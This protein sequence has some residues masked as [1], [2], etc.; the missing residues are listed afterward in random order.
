MQLCCWLTASEYPLAKL[1][2]RVYAAGWE[3]KGFADM[4]AQLHPK[5]T[6]G[7]FQGEAVNA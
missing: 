4:R 6:E 5:V 3:P 1:L 7:I 2:T